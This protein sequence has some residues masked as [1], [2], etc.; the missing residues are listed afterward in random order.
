E[1]VFSCL[2]MKNGVVF[3]NLN[4]SQ[5]MDALNFSPQTS[6]LK[7]PVKTVLSNSFGFGGNNSTLIFSKS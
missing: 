4:F 1:A 5:Q 6:L 3:P 2:A 7:K